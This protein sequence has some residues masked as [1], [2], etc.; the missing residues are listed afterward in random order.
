MRARA[1]ELSLPDRAGEVFWYHTIDLLG[2][3]ATPGRYDHRSLA[4]E[5]VFPDDLTSR[6]ALDIATFPSTD[7]GRS[8]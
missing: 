5:Y 7:S 8:S 1:A 4:P 6:R 3:G 2:G